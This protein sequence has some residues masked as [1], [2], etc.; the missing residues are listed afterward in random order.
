MKKHI[1]KNNKYIY[2][3]P[4]NLPWDWSTDYTNQTAFELSKTDV[5]VCYMLGEVKSIKEYI[6][7]KRVPKLYKKHSDNIYFFYP[8]LLI[9]LRRF[10]FI[11]NLN[12]LLSLF[13][14]K[15]FILLIG[16]SNNIS[17]KILWNFDPIFENISSSFGKD[18]IKI[19][20]CVDFFAGASTTPKERK[21][22]LTLEEKLVKSCDLVFANS[23]VLRK[24]L[25]RFRKDVNLVPQGFRVDSFKNYSKQ[26]S[27]P[28]IKNKNRLLV[29][30][31]GAVNHRIDYKLLYAVIKKHKDWDLAIWG[32]KL[33]FD[34][35]S[36]EQLKYFDRLSKTDNVIWG[37][38]GKTEVP[39]V[40]G[41]FDIGLIPYTTNSDFNKYCYPMK[42]FEYFYLGK[43]VVSVEIEELK[44][45]PQFVK[46][47][48]NY[49]QFDG[50]LVKLLNKPWSK[51]IKAK[52]RAMAIAN[53]WKAKV[54]EINKFLK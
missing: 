15:I 3:I 46:V 38:S 49:K 53:S 26:P 9:P 22:I 48:Y 4:F 13:L 2:L 34:L 37:S 1:E 42:L 47:A 51:N 32:P 45:F 21:R 35:L 25:T 19:Y 39:G 24:H 14:L 29:G 31:L 27:V 36:K 30:Y 43:P 52:A 41:Q 23:N 10:R 40:L 7:S 28:K 5:V 16:I 44:R 18:W 11:Y 33:E 12:I 20:D 17:K 54:L 6:Y 8:I 50:E